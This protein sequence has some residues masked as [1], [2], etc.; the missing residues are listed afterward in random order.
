MLSYKTVIIID[1]TKCKSVLTIVENKP[2]YAAYLTCREPTWGLCK[3]NFQ[4]S[5]FLLRFSSDDDLQLS[6][7]EF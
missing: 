5:L 4:R 7:P 2:K 1:D 3:Y 6:K